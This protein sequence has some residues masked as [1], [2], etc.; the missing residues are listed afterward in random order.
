MDE[1]PI[2]DIPESKNEMVLAKIRVTMDFSQATLDWFIEIQN[3]KETSVELASLPVDEKRLQE[4]VKKPKEIR[5]EQGRLIFKGI[6]CEQEEKALK[7]L[8]EDGSYRQA[9]QKLYRE[10]QIWFLEKKGDL[11]FSKDALKRLSELKSDWEKFLKDLVEEET[12]EYFVKLGVSKE[13]L[14]SIEVTINQYE[15]SLEWML[16]IA[17]IGVTSQFFAEYPKIKKG[18]KELSED[19]CKY[20]I[21]PIKTRL[22]KRVSK[23]SY[24]ILKS[25]ADK[26]NLLPPPPEEKL[27]SIDIRPIV[28]DA[29]I[30]ELTQ[31][32]FVGLMGAYKE[33][34]KVLKDFHDKNDKPSH[35]F[36][37]IES[38][39]HQPLPKL[40]DKDSNYY[41]K[42]AWIIHPFPYRLALHSLF[43]T[44][45][46]IAHMD[47]PM[48]FDD[49]VFTKHI[50]ERWIKENH[51]CDK[52]DESKQNNE[53]KFE[54]LN[55]IFIDTQE[56]LNLFFAIVAKETREVLEHNANKLADGYS[57]YCLN[58]FKNLLENLRSLHFGNERVCNDKKMTSFLIPIASS[59]IFY[60]D[61][62]VCVPHFDDKKD[63]DK[64]KK[65]ASELLRC[66][67]EHYV[68]A[69]ALIHE[70]FFEKLV[71]SKI[72]KDIDEKGISSKDNS[73]D[74]Y[75]KYLT[76]P[77]LLTFNSE[78][79]IKMEYQSSI[80]RREK[81]KNRP[82]PCYSCDYFGWEKSSDNVVEKYLHKL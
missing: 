47:F 56:F 43:L 16:V 74:K 75:I 9:I 60:G 8:S 29:D 73:S 80:C 17:I 6:M 39:V 3:I 71:A 48:K 19:F 46:K 67:K 44:D 64:L 31:L 70:H 20:I 1:K 7:R 76:D 51:T 58:N 2:T 14:P 57:K 32:M 23:D 59:Q 45:E 33:V 66:V 50:Y 49:S 42:E 4:I 18:M 30:S 68:P 69:L 21:N 54:K 40:K 22:G 61:L 24:D 38:L 28:P 12:K 25:E 35:G 26:I 78:R 27:V 79:I 65:L 41:H 53:L 72:T 37:F 36:L 77:Y 13:K 62:F 34:E 63:E 55:E 11:I 52:C 81:E 15:G 82:A 5:H 10:S